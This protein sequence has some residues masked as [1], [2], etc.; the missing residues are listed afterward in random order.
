VSGRRTT[1]TNVLVAMTV[2]LG[3]GIAG[4]SAPAPSTS[5]SPAASASPLFSTLLPTVLPP[6][7]PF[8]Y[9]DSPAAQQALDRGRVDSVLSAFS[10]GV[11]RDLLLDGRVVGGV[12]FYRFRPEVAASERMHFP[13]MI[14]FTFAGAS[15]HQGKVGGQVVQRVDRTDDGRTVIGW[16][17]D[18]YVVVVWTRDQHV[19]TTYVGDYVLRSM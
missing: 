14:V 1:V 5:S 12:L 6:V 15:P 13:P 3:L 11:S 19:A 2:V 4:C 8:A 16:T 18:D 9:A 10:G 17:H 7:P